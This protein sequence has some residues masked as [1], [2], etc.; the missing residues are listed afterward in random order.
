MNLEFG[1]N[2]LDALYNWT[3]C[4]ILFCAFNLTVHFHTY[5]WIPNS[6][7]MVLRFI[8]FRARNEMWQNI[9]SYNY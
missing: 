4:R 3:F 6:N 2:I 9:L 8:L 7:E 5:C 1:G